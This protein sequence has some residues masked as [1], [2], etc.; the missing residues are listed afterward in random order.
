MVTESRLVIDGNLAY[1]HFDT[2]YG[3]ITPPAFP[4]RTCS[5]VVKDPLQGTDPRCFDKLNI[6]FSSSANSRRTALGA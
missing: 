5:Y 2:P 3:H 1:R 4:P 6:S